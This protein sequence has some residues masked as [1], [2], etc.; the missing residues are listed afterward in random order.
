MQ[1]RRIYYENRERRDKDDIV[2]FS[3]MESGDVFE[4]MD[5]E[6]RETVFMKIDTNN[7]LNA[8]N[9]KTGIPVHMSVGDKFNR[10]KA[11]LVIE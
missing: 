6:I 10:L 3:E 2:T 5:P 9:L 11:K 4:Y 7:S 8:V 1:I